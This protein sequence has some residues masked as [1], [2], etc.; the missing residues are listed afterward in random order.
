[1]KRKKIFVV[2]TLTTMMF[3]G[4]YISSEA[5]MDVSLAEEVAMVSTSSTATE[6][7]GTC[8]ENLTWVL[9]EGTLKI[10]GFGAMENY[11]RSNAAP[12]KKT[13]VKKVKIEDGVTTIGDYAFESC[14]NLQDIELS[15]SITMIGD[16]AFY[17][18]KSLA[19]IALPKELKNYK[20]KYLFWM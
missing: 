5:S 13:D 7:A 3:L 16:S 2:A 18:C 17:W 20:T 12:W 8:G 9:E 14:R 15:D 1:M 6:N 11:S 19:E 4:N 10:S